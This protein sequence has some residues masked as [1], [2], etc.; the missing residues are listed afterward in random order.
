M[1]DGSSYVQI[2][3]VRTNLQKRFFDV[4]DFDTPSELLDAVDGMEVDVDTIS[5]CRDIR[6]PPGGLA[7]G[8]LYW[9]LFA[10]GY[11]QYRKSSAISAG[12]VYYDYLVSYF[13]D[14]G[15]N[16]GMRDDLENLEM[17]AERVARRYRDFERLARTQANGDS[18][19][20]NPIRVT[21]SDPPAPSPYL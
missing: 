13:L 17:A 7:D 20:L 16:P 12:N 11:L 5:R 21:V 6:V 1:S 2:D 18:K 15:H 4:F 8:W 10:K 9:L 3:V 19:P 14:Q